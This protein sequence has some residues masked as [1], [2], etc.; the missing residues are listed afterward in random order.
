MILT[1]ILKKSSNLSNVVTAGLDTAGF[2]IPEH[3]VPLKLCELTK[4]AI[5]G[6]SAN[7]SGNPPATN[8]EEA[9]TRLSDSPVDLFL[10]GGP[11][12]SYYPSTIIDCSNNS[13]SVIRA[14]VIKERD[15]FRTLENR[16]VD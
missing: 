5:V 15:L 14:G 10:D 8:I 9:I 12:G 13:P 2:R 7:K 16:G 3:N 4:G 6:T 1:M 11:S